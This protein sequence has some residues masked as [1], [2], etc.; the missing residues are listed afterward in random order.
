MTLC[1]SL[2][3]LTFQSFTVRIVGLKGFALYQLLAGSAAL[4]GS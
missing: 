3:Q 4:L 2:D 1:F